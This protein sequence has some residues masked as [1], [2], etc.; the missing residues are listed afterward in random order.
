ML[1]IPFGCQDYVGF[2]TINLI[3]EN[4][5]DPNKKEI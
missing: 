1:K 2:P 5:I 4:H 3:E